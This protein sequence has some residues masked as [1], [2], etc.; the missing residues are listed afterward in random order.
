MWGASGSVENTNK[1]SNTYGDNTPILSDDWLKSFQNY[2]GNLNSGG[3]NAGQQQGTDWLSSNIGP[4]SAVNVGTAATNNTLGNF[5]NMNLGVADQYKAFS[6]QYVPQ[7][8]YSGDVTAGTGAGAMGAYKNPW[9]NDVINASVND[10][11]ANTDRTL[12]GMRAGRDASGAFGDRA[13]VADA[14]YQGDATRG[15][16]SLVSGLRQTGF[17]TQA[18][19]GQQDASRTLLA[20]QGNQSARDQT[21]QFNANADLAGRGQQLQGIAGQQSAIAQATGVSQQYLQNIV[22]ADGV[23]MNKANALVNSGAITQ[24]QLQQI[25]DLATSGNGSSYTQNSSS[26]STTV[27]AKA[28]LSIP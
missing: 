11:N 12:N 6:N 24:A 13:A 28:G 25:V 5:N 2:Q 27:G 20:D 14:V 4:T 1:D 7:A 22:T 3:A 17:N 19:L 21:S 26:N 18:G 16:G 15:L 9:D 8:S 23:D 10:Y